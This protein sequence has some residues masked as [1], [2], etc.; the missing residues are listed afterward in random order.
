M[1]TAL[2]KSICCRLVFAACI[3]L[4]TGCVAWV[5]RPPIPEVA[6]VP[7]TGEQFATITVVRKEQFALSGVVFTVVLDGVPIA[8]LRTGQYLRF[9]V[10]PSE[11]ILQVRWDI[12]GLNI[13][14]AGPGGGGGIRDPASTYE[15]GIVIQCAVGDDCLITIAAKAFAWN[16]VDRV[17]LNKVDRLEGD[18]SLKHKASIVPGAV[19]P[20]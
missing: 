18:F 7:E 8:N 19:N 5:D 20:E 16:E 15:K 10:A 11:H 14:G 2:V 3:L 1:R 4:E 9:R 6:A 13:F 17:I 12:G